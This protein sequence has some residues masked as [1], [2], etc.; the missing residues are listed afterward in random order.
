M[1]GKVQ[2]RRTVTPNAPPTGLLEGELAVEMA[3]PTKLWVGVPTS[4]D[5]TG[6]KLLIDTSAIGGGVDQAY[7]DSENAAQDT[8]INGKVAKAG[9]TMTGLLVLSGPPTAALGAA[10]KAYA[11]LKAPLASPTF[12][13]V[14]A[15]PT[16]A[17]A[18]ST[19]QIATTA[20]V[21][22]AVGSAGGG[23]MMTSVYD[24]DTDGKVVSAVN[25]DIAPWAGISGKPPTYPPT[26]PIAQSGV[27]NLTADLALKA[28]LASPTFTGVPAG[29]TAA[30]GT[31]TTQ[32]ATT[33]FVKSQPFAVLPIAQADVTNLV[34]DLAL[35]APL[36]SPA[37]TGVP[38]AP[39]AA[40]ATN[41]T[42]V[43]TTAFVKTQ[44]YAPLA[45]PVF[46]GNPTAP[47]PAAADNDTSIATTA[48]VTAAIAGKVAKA[49]DTMTGLLVLSG[50]P[51]AALGAAT[52][53]Y[54]DT[55]A[56]LASP[57]FTGVPA[58][59]TAAAGTNTTQLATT[60]FVTAGV[61]GKV[62]K[63]G[64]T[65]TGML[66]LPATVPTLAT[67]A[68]NKAY[69]DGRMFIGDAPPAA[70]TAGQ[71]WWHSNLGKTFLWYTDANGSQWVEV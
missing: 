32:L 71:L 53:A 12:T 52:K 57:T 14:P 7:V 8:V 47:T 22:A 5:A 11:D 6:K 28:P 50:P 64:D 61:G 44:G 15:A 19:T 45:S 58:A 18:T 46:T 17:P 41:T 27:T 62:A 33:A 70:P 29:P 48:F 43:A 68:T 51:T 55:K 3:T 66:V 30:V 59:P 26:L 16:A 10:T 63:A 65:M 40:V 69:V 21:Q 20:F 25:A 37:L 54:A 34:A 9:D 1:A 4:L 35:K 67:H 36:A 31:N 42:Q 39:T 56:P 24:P 2:I 60:A 49:G 38:T 23:D 13:G